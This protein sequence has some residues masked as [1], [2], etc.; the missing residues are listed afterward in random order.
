MV[1]SENPKRDEYIA[2]LRELADWLEQNPKTS[3][4]SYGEI[5]LP[6]MANEA[7]VAHAAAAGLEVR[8]DSKGNASAVAK[9]GAVTYRAYGYADWDQH[10]AQHQEQRARDWADK[11]DMVI[12]PREGGA[13]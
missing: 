1:S 5:L 3:V 8:Y 10:Y 11:N 12:Q 7:V 13:R 9:L 4:P 2:G 6:L